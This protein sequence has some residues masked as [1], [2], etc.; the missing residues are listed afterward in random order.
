MMKRQDQVIFYLMGLVVC[1]PTCVMAQEPSDL[2]FHRPPLLTDLSPSGGEKEQV[3]APT[4]EKS[5]VPAVEVTSTFDEARL[6]AMRS[7]PESMLE[8]PV[9]FDRMEALK[10]ELRKAVFVVRTT[11]APAHTLA[12]AG[13]SFDGACV[14][15]EKCPEG[16]TD[17]VKTEETV[18][19]AEDNPYSFF[20]RDLEQYS[21]PFASRESRAAQEAGVSTCYLTT[22]DWLTHVASVQIVI[23]DH[24]VQAQ[25]VKRDEAQNVAILRTPYQAFV[26]GRHVAAF[27]AP[28]SPVAYALLEPGKMYESFTQQ[29]FSIDMP[30]LY[31]K[32]SLLARNGYPLFNVHGEIVGLTVAPIPDRTKANV[33]HYLLIDRALYPEKYDR[34]VNEKTEFIT[35]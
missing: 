8:P 10:S 16:M 21:S 12:S 14:A 35:Y 6:R 23:E 19:S 30:H 34:T 1:F 25:V 2:P 33:V 5:H 4:A 27:D 26:K 18:A 17:G 31:G 7:R 29:S 22:A 24:P 32:T 20:G 15:L 28:Q 9:S 13:V 11:Q 3:N